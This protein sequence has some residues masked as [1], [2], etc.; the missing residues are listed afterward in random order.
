MKRF[1]LLLICIQIAAIVIMGQ[2]TKGE[3]QIPIYP[4]LKNKESFS[5]IMIPDPQSY[6]KFAANQPLFELQNKFEQFFVHESSWQSQSLQ[7]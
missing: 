5:M 3:P 4:A 7:S 2:N 6:V 1:L